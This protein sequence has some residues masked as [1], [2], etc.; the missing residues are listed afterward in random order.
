MP[1]ENTGFERMRGICRRHIPIPLAIT[2]AIAKYIKRRIRKCV[3]SPNAAFIFVNQITA[4]IIYLTIS[5]T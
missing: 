1:I 5:Q 4:F 3:L 2:H